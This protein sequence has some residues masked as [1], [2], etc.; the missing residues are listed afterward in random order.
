MDLQ[1]GSPPP[2]KEGCD[3]DAAGRCQLV[4]VARK[5][6]RLVGRVDLG[7]FGPEL[8]LRRQ[9]RLQSLGYEL[10]VKPDGEWLFRHE[11]KLSCGRARRRSNSIYLDLQM[12]DRP[13]HVEP[14]RRTPASAKWLESWARSGGICQ[15]PFGGRRAASSVRGMSSRTGFAR[16][17]AAFV[18]ATFALSGVVSMPSPSQA[19]AAHQLPAAGSRAVIEAPSI[20]IEGARFA[21]TVSIPQPRRATRVQLQFRDQHDYDF[22]STSSWTSKTAKRTKGRQQVVFH[23]RADQ[24]NQAWFRAVVSYRGTSRSSVSAAARVNY[25]HWFPLSGFDR[26]Y[27]AGSL[28]DW[29]SFSMAGRAWRGWYSNGVGGEARYTLGGGCVRIRAT[30]GVTDSLSDGAS[31]T[32]AL[33]TIGP[34]GSA[35]ALYASPHL[36]AGQTH[37]ID[38]ALSKPFRLS[39][40]GQ[41]VTPSVTDDAPQPRAFAALGDPEFLCHFD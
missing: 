18:L 40:S 3:A 11:P 41:D 23:V 2:Y 24:A 13:W 37:S 1:R 16:L 21:I 9:G 14:T 28:I 26:Y 29:M 32:I 36:A 33:A 5:H 10:L 12:A 31:A 35:S 20:A 22:Q 8:D 17:R 7:A 38:L 30:V 4:D 25:Q 27:S 15:N 19:W 6:V 39:I 34:G